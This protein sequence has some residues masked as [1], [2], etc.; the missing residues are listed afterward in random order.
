MEWMM[1]IDGKW[2]KGERE[3]TFDTIN[4]ADGSILA[5]IYES[6]VND[7]KEAIKAAKYS[8][9]KDRSWRDMD[10]Q[11]RGDIL[12]KIADILASRKDEFARLEV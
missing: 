2:T 11:T 6:S 8:F 4:P 10:S 3:K 5:S 7:A 1:Y 9:Y 12:L